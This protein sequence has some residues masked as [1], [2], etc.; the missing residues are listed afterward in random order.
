V[1]GSSESTTAP[2]P[3]R[4][5]PPVATPLTV[6]PDSKPNADRISETLEARAV[7]LVSIWV[8]TMADG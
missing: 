3:C 7:A 8:A 5:W 1:V 6:A 2:P 4:N